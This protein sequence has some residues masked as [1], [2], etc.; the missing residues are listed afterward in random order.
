LEVRIRAASVE[1][2]MRLLDS[3]CIVKTALLSLSPSVAKEMY[4]VLCMARFWSLKNWFSFDFFPLLINFVVSNQIFGVS[5]APWFNRN[6]KPN[7]NPLTRRFE[8]AT[9]S[10]QIILQL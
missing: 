2:G 1:V 9:R 7:S 8:G 5:F 3:I 10:I 6:L 4:S